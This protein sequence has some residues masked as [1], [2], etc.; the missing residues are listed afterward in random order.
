MNNQIWIHLNNHLHYLDYDLWVNFVNQ[1]KLHDYNRHQLSYHLCI[2][3]D[4]KLYNQFQK[5]NE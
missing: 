5:I 1:M 4:H 2:E 3:L